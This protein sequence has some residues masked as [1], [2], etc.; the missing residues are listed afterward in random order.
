MADILTKTY[1]I[2]GGLVP[3]FSVNPPIGIAALDVEFIDEQYLQEGSII[4]GYITEVGLNNIIKVY[5]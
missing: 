1:S 4:K 2:I 5:R 3:K